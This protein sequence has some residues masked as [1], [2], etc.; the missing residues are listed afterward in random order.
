MFLLFCAPLVN[1]G[2]AQA[3]VDGA[4]RAQRSIYVFELFHD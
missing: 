3:R 4:G 2:R 1:A